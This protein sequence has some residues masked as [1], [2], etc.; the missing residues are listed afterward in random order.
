MATPYG[1]VAETVWHS[2]HSSDCPDW[3]VPSVADITELVSSIDWLLPDR[4]P[5]SR[6][7]ARR[8]GHRHRQKPNGPL[9]TGWRSFTTR[10]WLAYWWFVRPETCVRSLPTPNPSSSHSPTFTPMFSRRYRK[11]PTTGRSI[12]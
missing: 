12:R 11:T 7:T 4:A 5:R 3:A 8:H 6:N 10:R 1:H 9:H 2:D